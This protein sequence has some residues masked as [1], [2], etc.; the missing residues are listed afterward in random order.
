MTDLLKQLDAAAE[1]KRR[2]LDAS[3]MAEAQMMDPNGR[4]ASLASQ[5]HYAADQIDHAAIA[6]AWRAKDAEIEKYRTVT[7]AMLLVMR[8]VAARAR[9]C[10]KGGGRYSMAGVWED[11][12]PAAE[13]A[14]AAITPAAGADHD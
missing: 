11:L 10:S 8:S 6:A 4:A 7:A 13:N 5:H 1:L 3:R 14:E 2:A 12:A 9:E